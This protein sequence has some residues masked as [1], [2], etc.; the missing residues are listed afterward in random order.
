MTDRQCG[1]AP[2]VMLGLWQRP[3]RLVAV[4]DQGQPL[5]LADTRE[6]TYLASLAEGL[7]GDV[8]EMRDGSALLFGGKVDAQRVALLRT[9][10][11]TLFA[12]F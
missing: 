10:K 9:I 1:G 3:D 2:L 8:R 5:H 7:P 11:T 4:R 12:G 6:G